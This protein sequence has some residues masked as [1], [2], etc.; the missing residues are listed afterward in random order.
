MDT[1]SFPTKGNL[2]AAK[3]SLELASHGYELMDKKRNI[4]LRE[5]M[6]M[7][8]EAKAIQGEI[9]DTY[10]SAYRALQL[11]NIRVG[12]HNVEDISATV[13]EEN[14]IKIM[15]RSIMGT[16]IPLVSFSSTESTP[17]YSF[18]ATSETLDN[19]RDHFLKVKELT[20]KL[21]MVETSAYRL[22]DSIQKTQKRANALNNITIPKLKVLI[23]NI[24][25]ALEEKDREEFT[26]LKVIKARKTK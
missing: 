9:D 12:I 21:S 24:N 11:A 10:A 13:P 3:S 5:L 6:G 8:S 17:A 20:I 16:E 15:T 25:D 7:I 2:L 4:L 19:A 1:S 26:R 14:S 18:Y 23:K 22:A